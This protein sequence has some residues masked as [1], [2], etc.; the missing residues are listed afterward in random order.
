MGPTARRIDD[1]IIHDSTVFSNQSQVSE[2]ALVPVK[3][4]F[5]L[6]FE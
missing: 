5:V 3:K 1:S 2:D 4:M 6:L